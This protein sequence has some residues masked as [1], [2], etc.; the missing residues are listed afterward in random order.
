MLDAT[1]IDAMFRHARRFQPTAVVSARRL[2][3][4]L[5]W[6]SE[7]GARLQAQPG[8]WELTDDG[9]SWTI[10][11]DAFARSYQARSDGRYAKKE[12]V[13]AVRL[14]EPVEVSTAEGPSTGRPG[15]WLVRDP[16]GAVWPVPDHTFRRRY[17]PADRSR[18]M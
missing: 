3:R 5:S 15:D 1:E 13:Q 8:D 4:P 18:L 2:T 6:L 16:V 17:R 7:S 12:I 9:N 10:T 11:A 14:A